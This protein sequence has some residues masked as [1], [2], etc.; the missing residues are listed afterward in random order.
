MYNFDW[1]S[2]W[3]QTVKRQLQAH[4]GSEEEELQNLKQ[5]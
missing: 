4:L 3:N 5:E 2:A 1:T